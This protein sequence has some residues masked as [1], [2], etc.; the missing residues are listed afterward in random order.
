MTQRSAFDQR[1]ELRERT[2]RDAQ[3]V[4]IILASAT[5]RHHPIRRRLRS[6]PARTTFS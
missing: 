1:D 3:L 5:P 2:R 6:A 4:L